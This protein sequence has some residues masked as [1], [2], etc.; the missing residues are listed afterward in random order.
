MERIILYSISFL[1]YLF[2][3]SFLPSLHFLVYHILAKLVTLL[4]S[5]TFHLF[6]EQMC[7]KKADNNYG[8]NEY[9][10]LQIKG[11]LAPL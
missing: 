9:Q 7:I 8:I 11:K 2:D 3:L 1:H 5:M 4:D 10:Q 6:P